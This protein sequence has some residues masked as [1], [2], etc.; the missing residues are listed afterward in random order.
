MFKRQPI[1]THPRAL[2]ILHSAWANTRNRLSFTTEAIC[3]LP[4][5]LHCLWRLPEGDADFSLRWREIK[6]LC[7]RRYLKNIGPGGFRNESRIRK[8][9][10]AVWRR[11]F[12]EHA[13]R[14]QEDFNNHVAYIHMNP[15]KHGLVKNVKNWPWSSFHRYVE[16]G[17]IDQ[18]W[19]GVDITLD[20]E[21]EE[22]SLGGLTMRRTHLTWKIFSRRQPTL[23]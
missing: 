9:E 12:W 23:R 1:L 14:D 16:L 3:I 15:V 10:A 11:R 6:R 8:G 22:V 17:I 19:G 4:D 20:A 2:E 18:D 21:N 5:H 7:T 13:I